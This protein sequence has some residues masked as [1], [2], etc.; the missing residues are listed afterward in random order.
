ME[1][2]FYTGALVCFNRMTNMGNDQKDVFAEMQKIYKELTSKI[3]VYETTLTSLGSG[4]VLDAGIEK[5]ERI[6]TKQ[7]IKFRGKTYISEELKDY[8][9][10]TIVIVIIV[11]E[12]IM[13]YSKENKYIC[14]AEE[15]K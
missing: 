5:V 10:K 1:E 4:E 3:S 7:G 11:A 8:I 14:M 15:S 13:V 6:V 12:Y 2:A 9:G